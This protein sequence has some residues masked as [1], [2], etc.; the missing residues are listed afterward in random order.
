MTLRPIAI[1][2]V[3]ASVVPGCADSENG[4]NNVNH[5][6]G[7]DG[8]LPPAPSLLSVS[9]SHGTVAGGTTITLTGEH[10]QE[11]LAVTVDGQDATDIQYHSASEVRCL[12]PPATAAG[13]V[14]VRVTNPDLQYSELF[15]GFEYDEEVQPPEVTWCDLRGPPSLET[16]VSQPTAPIFGRVLAE[17]VTDLVG[18]GTGITA[19]IGWGPDDS[20][21]ASAGGWQWQDAVYS[22]DSSQLYDEYVASLTA[23]AS[24]SFDYAYRFSADGGI[25]WLYCDLDSSDNGYSAAAAGDLT[26][27]GGGGPLT[28]SAVDLPRGSVLG[29]STVTVT[30]A[31]FASDATVL[32][33]TTHSPQVVFVST[34]ELTVTVPTGAVGTVDVTV[35]SPGGASAAL[36][37][38]F[39]YVL[40]ASPTV[41]GDLTDWDPALQVAINTV[42]SGWSSANELTA[43]HVAFDDTHLYVGIDGTVEAAN[44]IVAYLDTDFGAATGI[45]DTLTITDQNGAFDATLGGG[46]GG[47]LLL[48]VTGFGA[49]FAFG[50][51]GMDEALGA[52]SDSAG[53][54]SL[55]N[56]GDLPWVLATVDAGNHLL[57]C[58]LPLADLFSTAVPATGATL[59][60][61]V[62]ITD[63]DGQ[64][65]A[66]QTLP[67]EAATNTVTQAF[68]FTIYPAGSY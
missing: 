8:G 66:D 14:N 34:A 33:G 58:G 43:L 2:L 63:P 17:T 62:K 5:T 13:L 50:S 51:K 9:P 65:F 6:S 30:G 27:G 12:T 18:M 55:S 35:G 49:E 56:P 15:G 28:L 61:V 53:L 41:D 39:E 3:L 11:G 40:A 4:N 38:A 67:E 22:G 60:L 10:F 45:T 44:A 57:E 7:N 36:P 37:G 29:G 52:M 19:Q 31:G 20:D 26:V 64:T 42:A 24:G 21:P 16:G 59:A 48:N 47:S 1:L 54:R 46:V 25:T 23:D 32:F 68:S